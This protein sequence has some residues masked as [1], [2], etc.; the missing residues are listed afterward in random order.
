MKQILFI[1]HAKS[2]HDNIYITDH[3]RDLTQRWI[4]DCEITLNILP[5]NIKKPQINFVSNS[6]RTIQT[7]K[8]LSN[9]LWTKHT[10]TQDLYVFTMDKLY[11][12]LRSIESKYKYISIIWHNEWLLDIINDLQSESINKF[13]T[14]SVW[15]IEFENI[16]KW[17]DVQPKTWVLKYIDKPK[18]Y[19]TK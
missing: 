8:L 12:F 19:K 14:C 17:Q 13:P 3:D 5:K 2:S 18:N 15:L 11:E 1:R 9:F 6:I 10:I 7:Y 16:T 4:S